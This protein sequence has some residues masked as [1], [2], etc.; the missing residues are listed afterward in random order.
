MSSDSGT[1]YLLQFLL[2][3]KH[4]RTENIIHFVHRFY[5]KTFKKGTNYT[6]NSVTNS[7]IARCRLEPKNASI[8]CF[9]VESSFLMS[10]IDCTF[11]PTFYR[12]VEANDCSQIKRW[13]MIDPFQLMEQMIEFKKP[14]LLILIGFLV[15]KYYRTRTRYEVEILVDTA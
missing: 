3:L 13:L 2:F 10:G 7:S 12:L 14:L 15:N 1:K 5:E 6:I 4:Y 9:T 11:L 8:N